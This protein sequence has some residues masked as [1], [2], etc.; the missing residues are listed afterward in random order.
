V[1]E[2]VVP[3]VSWACPTLAWQ[4]SSAMLAL[5]LLERRQLVLGLTFYF[6]RV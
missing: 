3:L 6:S 1:D 5:R 4:P 2:C